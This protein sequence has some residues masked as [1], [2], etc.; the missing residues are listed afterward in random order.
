MKAFMAAYVRRIEWFNYRVGRFAMYLIFVMMA[1]LLWSSFTKTAPFMRPSLWTLE[2]AQ[3][4]MVAYYMLGGP[5]SIQ[6]DTNVRMDLVY[7][8]MSFRRKAFVDVF[9]VLFLIT[10]LGFLLYGGSNSLAYAIEFNERSPTAWR[11]Y[12]WPVK[13]VMVIGILLML[14]QAFA[15]LFKDIERFRTGEADPFGPGPA[16]GQKVAGDA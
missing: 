3:Y 11:P 8:A 14:L 2:T 5:Y 1:V 7:G 13:T 16:A 6:L 10:Y 15:E 9:T 12:L 4:V